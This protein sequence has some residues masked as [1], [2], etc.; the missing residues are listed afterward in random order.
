MAPKERKLLIT[1]AIIVIAAVI[2]LVGV[3]GLRHRHQ[4]GLSKETPTPAPSV[5]AKMSSHPDF[6]GLD[7]LTDYG[8]SSYQLQ[9]VEYSFNQYK[10]KT[11]GQVKKVWLDT[12]TLAS[13]EVPREQT[14]KAVTFGGMFND[15]AVY[16]AK[17]EYHGLTKSR[18]YI[19]DDKDKLLYDSGTV[20]I[21]SG[22]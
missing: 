9:N 6:D 5:A 11:N 4:A 13:V 10:L 16:R 15:E 8:V 18:L 2:V 20:D 17:V 21:Y 14:I 3:L 19:Y 22:Q 1:C 12:N 7:G